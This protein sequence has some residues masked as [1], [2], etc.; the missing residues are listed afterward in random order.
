MVEITTAIIK[1]PVSFSPRKSADTITVTTGNNEHRGATSE[2][3]PEEYAT[4]CVRKAALPRI[5]TTRQAI[6][7]TFSA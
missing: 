2:V 4:D 1:I 3:M 6:K 5:P 7:L